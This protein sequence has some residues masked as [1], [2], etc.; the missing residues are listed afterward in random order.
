MLSIFI[1]LIGLSIGS[2]LNVLIDRLPIGESIWLDR[3]HCDNCRKTLNWYDL[4]PVISFIILQRKCRSCHK[5][6][7]WQY[8][9]VELSTGLIFLFTYVSMMQIIGTDFIVPHLIYYLTLVASLIAIFMIDLKYRI[10]PDQ[11]LIFLTVLTLVYQFIYF[12]QFIKDNLISGIISM[13]FFL[14]LVIV[15]RGKGMGLGD[16]K[17]AFVMGLLL[18]FPKIIVALYLS[19]LTGAVVSLILILIHKK[20]MKSTIAFGPFLVFSTLMAVFYGNYFWQLFQEI[21]TL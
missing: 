3:S 7:S 11:I 2:F 9:L 6:I 21:F 12:P 15:T 19:F 13:S 10:I 8:P 4:I 17:L 18:G 1:F 5:K 20:S 16:V 14:L